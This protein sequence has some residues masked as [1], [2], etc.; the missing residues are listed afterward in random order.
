QVLEGLAYCHDEVGVV[1][2]DVKPENIM[3]S[4]A[5]QRRR[6]VRQAHRLRHR[7]A[8]RRPLRRAGRHRAVPCAGGALR[9][10]GAPGRGPVESAGV[11]LHV[12]LTG[13]LLPEAIQLGHE[14]LDLER[15]AL[16][17]RRMSTPAKDTERPHLWPPAA[18]PPRA[19]DGGCRGGTPLAAPRRP[20]P[21]LARRRRTGVPRPVEGAGGVLWPAGRIL[22]AAG[23]EAEVPGPRGG[24]AGA[25]GQGDELAGLVRATAL[26][27]AAT[28]PFCVAE[29]LSTL[30]LEGCGRVASDDWLAWLVAAAEGVDAAYSLAGSIMDKAFQ[31]A[32]AARRG[33][34]PRQVTQLP[35][36]CR[37]RAGVPA[38]RPVSVDLAL[39][40]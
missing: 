19:A 31:A 3:V 11:V 1:H 13:R 34:A 29:A 6:P 23:V 8:R 12:L 28:L 2:R 16:S 9:R 35:T 15:G 24:L 33:A 26:A 38:R 20:G 32:G 27:G 22:A 14:H 37:S 30:D 40:C 25:R 5:G 36:P 4:D 10:A 17:G 39:A 7:A 18:R 21:R